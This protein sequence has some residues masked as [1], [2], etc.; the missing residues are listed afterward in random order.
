VARGI[1]LVTCTGHKERIFTVDV[2]ADGQ[3]L[4]SAGGEDGAILWN[5]ADGT[6]K[7]TYKHYYVRSARF[8]SDGRWVL[9]GSYDGTTRLW[10][11]ATG[12]QRV[13][14]EGT[15]GVSDL[16]FSPAARTLAVCGYGRNLCLFNLTLD[17]PTAKERERIDALLAKLDDD[18]YDV[19][20]AASD[21]LFRI[22]FVAEAALRQAVKQAKSVEVR[23]RARRIRQDLLSQPR[24]HLRGHT[25]DVEAAVFSPDGRVLA[26]GGKD[27]VARLWD[28]RTAKQT[29]A[30]TPQLP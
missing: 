12:E 3:Y 28:V 15:G 17:P 22:G 1:E 11:L 26:S 29:A 9:T 7:R 10:S 4:L 16:A 23:V 2:S 24:A 20:E 14:F 19:R 27:G 5:V 8:T 13:R 30:L 21:E 25:G 18:S 6:Q